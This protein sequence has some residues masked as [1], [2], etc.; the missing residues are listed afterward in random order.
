MVE[1]FA[2]GELELNFQVE[3]VEEDTEAPH[4]VLVVDHSIQM[5]VVMVVETVVTTPGIA[6]D[7]KEEVVAVVAGEFLIG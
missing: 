4:L 5:I 2:E 7:K 6:L 1:Q 3:K